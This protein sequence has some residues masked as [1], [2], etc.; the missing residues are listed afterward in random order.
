MLQILHKYP[1]TPRQFYIQ[2]IFFIVNITDF[3]IILI[4]IKRFQC[5]WV[6]NLLLAL[7][8]KFHKTINQDKLCTLASL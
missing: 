6:G 4:T 3:R 8:L 1:G 2:S 5:L 7:R